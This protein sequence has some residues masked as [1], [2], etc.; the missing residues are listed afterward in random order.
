MIVRATTE[1]DW[2]ILKAIRLAAL[3]DAPTAFGITHASAAAN[4]DEQWR[5][6]AANRGPG[7]FLLALVD[8]EAVG[9][10]GS[11]VSDS[12]ELNLIAM[13]V[14]PEHRGSGAAARLVEAVKAR[15]VAE[16]RAK[17]ILDVSPDNARAAAF[18]RKQGFIFED[19]VEPLA[20]HP[21]INVQKMAW[22]VR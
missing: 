6:R 2:A 7:R 3:L 5:D 11:V 21:N 15:A 4:T 17:L 18:Y 14:R 10:V 19:H 9:L 12:E 13:W 8:G 16:G 20:S 1:E 22:P